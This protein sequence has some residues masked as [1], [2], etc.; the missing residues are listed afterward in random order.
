MARA[1]LANT[2]PA[3]LLALSNFL[4]QVFQ[5]KIEELLPGI[6]LKI[7]S[8]IHG[9]RGSTDLLFSNV[10]FE[11]KVDLEK[12]LDDAERK[13]IKYLRIFH[14]DD[15]DEKHVGLATDVVKF[16]SYLPVVK[17]GEVAALKKIG[18]LNLEKSSFEEAVWWLDSFFFSKVDKPTADDLKWRFGPSSPTYVLATEEL[19]AMW[20]EIEHNNDA[21]LKF[22]LWAKNMEMVYG[23]KPEVRSF[24][25]HAFLVTLVKLIVYL[26]MRETT[27]TFKK[28]E[29][30]DAINGEFFKRY[31]IINFIEE[32]FFAW[33]LYP[34]F[35]ERITEICYRL[36]KGLLCYDMSQVNEDLFKEIY[37]EIVGPSERHKV[38]EYYT[39]EWLSELTLKETLNEW[40]KENEGTPKIIDPACGSGT[41]LTNA[42]RWVREEVIARGGS[43]EE[44]TNLVLNNV[45]GVDINPLAA[46]IARANY[47]IALGE[48]VPLFNFTIPVYIADSI[49]TPAERKTTVEGVDVY[50][51][52]L[53]GHDIH[54]P[55]SVASNRVR[56]GQFLE[57]IRLSLES[58][59]SKG[60]K[61]GA[62]E[63]LKRWSGELNPNELK[64]I[65]STLDTLIK[66]VKEGSDTIWTF[67]LSNTYAPIVLAE[68]RFDV[69]VGNP[70]WVSMRYFEDAGYQN[71]LKKEVIK[72]GLLDKKEVHLFTQMEMA[73]LFFCKASEMYLKRKGVI[74]FVMPR[75][76]L[77]GALHHTKFK[78]FNR[79]LMRLSRIL[80]SGEVSPLFKVPS[81]VLV[82]VRGLETRYPVSASKY[83]GKLGR[84][85]ERLLEA[86]KAFKVSEY[87]YKPPT[88]PTE[89][90]PYY[91]QVKAG[92]AIYP[93]C[94]YFIEF[95]VPPLGWITIKKPAVK[96]SSNLITKSPWTNVKLTGSIESD[97]IYVTLLGGDIVRFGYTEFRLIVLPVELVADGYKMLDV[98]ELMN[99]GLIGITNWL[100][101]IQTLWERKRTEKAT[102]RFPR[103]MDS[104]DYY[105]LL[106]NQKPQ[107]RY[108][109]IYNSSGTNLV[110]CVIDKRMLPSFQV[111]KGGIK[112]VNY[113]ADKKTH[114][115]E[116]DN[117]LE[118]HYLCAVL[119]SG[120]I[121]SVIKPFQTRGLFGER[122]IG[123]RPF[124]F[125]IP[126]FEKDNPHHMRLAELS[127]LCHT[128]VSQLQLKRQRSA[129]ARKKA[130][131]IVEKEL[132]EID[133]IVSK[134]L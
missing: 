51:I 17:N 83:T 69:I 46:V 61:K 60:S 22:K 34:R 49:K 84:K 93:R 23:S 24:I 89:R 67:W 40:K 80:D 109:L 1:K 122:D 32:D 5:V 81:C 102:K 79:P 78:L 68:S 113:I 99:K 91:D 62:Y 88:I 98:E 16:I 75:S 133:D 9:V 47:I 48:D 6:E 65:R 100:E 18:E 108:N 50:G 45:V 124:M 55:I 2:H 125:S 15:P 27:T 30:M 85:N 72:Y 82:C 70:P 87:G 97:F 119:N 128:K 11:L 53:N 129:S 112:P 52:E 134:I 36:V 111:G 105:G 58:F 39:P 29:I 96:T 110:S 103:V 95:D 123:R 126:E 19:E 131:V 64:V 7:G 73:T 20:K 28:N 26:K 14:E 120:I 42:I 35:K 13:L 115:Y 77:T 76:V 130:T 33:M 3:K 107:T 25:E 116:T 127:K 43:P 90:S 74:G 71:F 12:E 106:T 57:G 8:K 31:G 10:V 92:A 114:F 104:V 117:E 56:F 118:A 94:F 86:Q 37:Q 101:M 44:A 66:L 21:K 41:F 4:D 59:K 54:L 132:Q 38:G 63:I 121:N